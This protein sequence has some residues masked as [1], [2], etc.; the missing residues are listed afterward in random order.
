MTLRLFYRTICALTVLGLTAMG[1]LGGCASGGATKP[2]KTLFTATTSLGQTLPAMGNAGGNAGASTEPAARAPNREEGA[3]LFRLAMQQ[4]PQQEEQALRLFEQSAQA[5]PTQPATQ[6]NLG[7]LYKRTGQLDKAIA[8]YEQAIA[9]QP[10]YPEA[11]YNLALAYRAR[12]EFKKAEE[13]Y[14][15]ALTFNDQFADARYNLGI[16]YDLYLGQPAKA[17]EQYRAYLR[18]NGP[19]TEEVSRWAA[20]LERLVPQEAPPPQ[21]A[22]ASV[23]PPAGQPGDA[24]L[25]GAAR[26]AAPE[27]LSR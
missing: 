20:A 27:I 16:L 9:R 22:P 10:N 4:F 26:A 7:I 17:L 18:L 13:A 6:N 23:P 12:G 11:H 25:R 19:H 21:Q 5:D 2:K 1:T 14:L 8:A 24:P 15:K 3:R